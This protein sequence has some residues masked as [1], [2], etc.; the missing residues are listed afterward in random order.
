MGYF[1]GFPLGLLFGALIYGMWSAYDIEGQY[2]EPPYDW[3]Q[4]DRDLWDIEP[5]LSTKQRRND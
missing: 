3:Q 1:I 2:K 4:M 5:V